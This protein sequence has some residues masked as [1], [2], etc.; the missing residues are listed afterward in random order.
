MSKS[1]PRIVVSI[2]SHGHGAMVAD[3]LADLSACTE[4]GLSVV[5][6]LNIPE[7]PPA[8]PAGLSV[9]VIRNDAPKGFGANHNAAFRISAGEYFCVLNPDVRFI[10]NPFPRLLALLDG[11]DSGVAAPL[12]V[13]SAGHHEDNARRFPTPGRLMKK[14]LRKLLGQ[15]HE[16]DYTPG[17]SP[18]EVDWVAGLMMLFG[19]PAYEQAG[20]F[21]ERFFLYYEDID[22]CARLR[23]AG[24]RV[25]VDPSARI[26]HEARRDSHRKLRFTLWHLRSV[27]RYM[28]S[29]VFGALAAKGWLK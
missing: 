7:S 24:N 28:A 22:L 4:P 27:L 20:G 2:V 26:V 14:L 9:S 15:P 23:L 10:E 29:P 25:M 3:L 13:T 1:P 6:T 16:L 19:F 17:G 5:L 12:A 21:D 11:P 18:F 8:V